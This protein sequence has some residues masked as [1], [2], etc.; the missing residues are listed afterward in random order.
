[1]NLIKTIIFRI[2][3]G[4]LIVTLSACSSIYKNRTIY[5]AVKPSDTLYSIAWRYQ[6]T[7]KAI[8]RKNKIKKPYVIR[9][10]DVI[11]VRYDKSITVAEV[12]AKPVK[13]ASAKTPTRTTS[14]RTPAIK[15]APRRVTPTKKPPT[16][17]ASN[18]SSGF[19]KNWSWP[20]N[21]SIT[22]AFGGN[23]GILKGI[24]IKAPKNT[25]VIASNGGEVVYAGNGL[26][27]YGKLIIIKHNE[28]YLSAYGYL[29]KLK[30]K[31]GDT[32]KRGDSIAK[33]GVNSEQQSLLHFE[34]RNKGRP[35]DPINYLPK[36]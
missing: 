10:G 16:R 31:E 36:R 12:K 25:N 22:T 1:M 4:F 29:S 7:V 33:L 32:I 9:V 2:I 26:R 5:Y 28:S 13:V 14:T 18:S 35:V 11:K 8:A 15:P 20:I 30:V 24:L 23:N 19:V 3:I 34:I 17:V 6:T 21:G 27:S